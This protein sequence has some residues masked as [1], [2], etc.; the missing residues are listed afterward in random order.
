MHVP[1]SARRDRHPPEVNEGKK[2]DTMATT[3]LKGKRKDQALADIKEGKLN[4]VELADRYG[5]TPDAIRYY[6]KKLGI[7]SNEP[8]GGYKAIER[9]SIIDDKTDEKQEVTMAEPIKE[10]PKTESKKEE[11]TE[12]EKVVEVEELKKED[13]IS[14]TVPSDYDPSKD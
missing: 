9:E 2:R 10:T 3:R 14:K 5:V 4:A 8:V 1:S 12:P 11:K 6:R 7:G 13:L